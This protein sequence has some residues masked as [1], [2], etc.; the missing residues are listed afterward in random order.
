MSLPAARRG[1]GSAGRLHATLPRCQ[2]P[3]GYRAGHPRGAE[4]HCRVRRAGQGRRLQAV[5]HRLRLAAPIK[6]VRTIPDLQQKTFVLL[7]FDDDTI[8]ACLFVQGQYTYSTHS[9]LFNPRGSA[10]SGTEIAQKLSGLIQFHT[11]SKSEHRIETV[12]FAGST[13]DALRS[14]A[15]AVRRWACRWPASRIRPPSSCRPAPRWPMCFTRRA[16]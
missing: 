7:Q 6:A 14:A 10:E 4:R 9:R 3:R 11:T 5:Q 8:S 12:C 15:R 13:A 2:D 16:T 1:Q